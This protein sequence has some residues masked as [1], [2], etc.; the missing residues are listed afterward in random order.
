MS[1]LR[2]TAGKILQTRFPDI[3]LDL[4]ACENRRNQQVAHFLARERNLCVR[5]HNLHVPARQRHVYERRKHI[6]DGRLHVNERRLHEPR[7]A[8]AA[9][10]LPVPPRQK[11]PRQSEA[12]FHPKL[13]R[14]CA[15]S[16]RF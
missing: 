1:P 12:K 11:L 13:W 9:G 14:T 5:G 6:H 10:V 16:N 3:S 4:T 8:A 2:T 7:T 15:F